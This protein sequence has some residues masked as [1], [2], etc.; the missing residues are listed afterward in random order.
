MKSC[1]TLTTPH[2]CCPLTTAETICTSTMPET[3]RKGMRFRLRCFANTKRKTAQFQPIFRA[4]FLAGAD[5]RSALLGD[6]DRSPDS[7]P[8]RAAADLSGAR[9]LLDSSAPCDES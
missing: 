5:D 3:S 2:N 4:Q 7:R 8:H 1:A 9:D 6:R